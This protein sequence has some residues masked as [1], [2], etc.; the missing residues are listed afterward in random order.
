M[1]AW[2]D[3]ELG[4]IGVLGT[5]VTGLSWLSGRQTKA[6]LARQGEILQGQRDL[7]KQMEAN[8]ITR[9]GVVIEK[10]EGRA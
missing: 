6:I 10:L 3:T 4:T 1:W 8:A 5:L 2:I 9:H 7:L